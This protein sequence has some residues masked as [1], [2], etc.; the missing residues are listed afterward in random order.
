MHKW[1]FCKTFLLCSLKYLS[2]RCHCVQID[3]STSNMENV[4]FRVPSGYILRQII[5]NG[6]QIIYYPQFNGVVTIVIAKSLFA[7]QPGTCHV[8]DISQK[9]PS[10]DE[11]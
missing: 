6:V 2:N 9:R 8:P 10:H 4:A 5:F 3:D 11:T 7:K 1:R